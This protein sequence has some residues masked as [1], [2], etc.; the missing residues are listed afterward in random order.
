MTFLCDFSC[1]NVTRDREGGGFNLHSCHVR[2]DRTG[3]D[4]LENAKLGLEDDASLKPYVSE[5]R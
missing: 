3:D 1:K 5:T 2:N 4:M